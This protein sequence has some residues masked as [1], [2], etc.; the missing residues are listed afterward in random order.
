M[1]YNNKLRSGAEAAEGLAMLRQ[2]MEAVGY[3]IVTDRGDCAGWTN[4]EET[5]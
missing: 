2:S 5:N 3:Q 4:G 1:L